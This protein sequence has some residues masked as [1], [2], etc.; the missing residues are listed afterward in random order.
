[1][2]GDTKLG[3]LS[4]SVDSLAMQTASVLSSLPGRVA[5]VFNDM[6]SQPTCTGTIH[7]T[8]ASE[9]GLLLAQ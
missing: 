1:M 5:T 3:E 9:D 8:F 6:T 4:P 7:A 2:G